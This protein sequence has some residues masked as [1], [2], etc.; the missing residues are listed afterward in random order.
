MCAEH[1]ARRCRSLDRQTVDHRL[2]LP[3]QVGKAFVLGR[4]PGEATAK[5]RGALLAQLSTVGPLR[6]RML[7]GFV[8]LALRLVPNG[9]TGREWP[10]LGAGLSAH[11]V[12]L[13]ALQRRDD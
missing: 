12:E 11:H 7:K 13:A 5:R 4:L 9:L 6:L 8:G 1:D 10:E 2:R 3:H